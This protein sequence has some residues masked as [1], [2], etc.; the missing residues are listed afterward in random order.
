MNTLSIHHDFSTGRISQVGIIERI[1][2]ELMRSAA[3]ILAPL[4]FFGFSWAARFV[5]SVFKSNRQIQM[6]IFD[7]S[8]FAYPYG[9]AY[10]G[11][12]LYNKRSY[13]PDVEPYLKLF[14][15]IDYAFID[16][17][18]NY[19]Y[20]S[21]LVSSAEYGAKPSIAIEADPDN[22]DMTVVNSKLNGK[23]FDY[24]HN[25]VFSESGKKVTL[26]GTKHEACSILEDVGGTSRGK[27]ETLALD[28]LGN[29]LRKKG[30]SKTILKL[31]IEGVEIDAL[32]GASEILQHDCLVIYEEHGSEKNNDVSHY[33]KD[34]LGMRLFL[35]SEDRLSMREIT[36]YDEI[37]ALKT[38]PRRGYDLFAATSEFWID[39]LTNIR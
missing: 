7:D 20:M 6:R 23:R 19:G 17:G 24:C 1:G 16:C 8:V 35:G 37:D 11:V 5:R 29:W 15:D 31:D 27:V 12:M 34:R 36:S 30:K 4:Q 13:A 10:W 21:V 32:K 14:A 9:D 2:L 22:Y 25:A 3:Y 33:L 38:N 18:A 39:K 28:D 26:Y